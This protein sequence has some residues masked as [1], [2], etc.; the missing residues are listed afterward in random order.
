MTRLPL[1]LVLRCLLRGLFC[2]SCSL[3]VSILDLNGSWLCCCLF[4]RRLWVG[5]LRFMCCLLLALSSVRL[6]LRSVLCGRAGPCVSGGLT[7]RAFPCL[8]CTWVR[9]ARCALMFPGFY[10][11]LVCIR[12]FSCCDGLKQ[13]GQVLLRHFP[14]R[15]FRGGLSC[16]IMVSR[17]PWARCVLFR[18]LWLGF[19]FMFLSCYFVPRVGIDV[20]LLMCRGAVPFSFCVFCPRQ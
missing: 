6:I 7:L 12:L 1:F 10:V 14:R 18:V 2:S 17:F 19:W 20:S 9:R 8:G 4:R 5:G 16:A 15:W 11:S 3:L 13:L